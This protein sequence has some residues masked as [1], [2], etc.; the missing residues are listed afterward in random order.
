MK[1][2][3][4]DYLR[5]DGEEDCWL[6]NPKRKVIPTIMFID[7]T[8]IVLICKYHSFMMIHSCPWKHHLPSD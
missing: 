4:D 8:M 2:Y 3:R 6:M 7:G 1:W 5:D